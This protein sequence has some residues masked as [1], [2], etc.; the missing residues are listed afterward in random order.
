M[1]VFEPNPAYNDAKAELDLINALLADSDG[2]RREPYLPRNAKEDPADY[3]VRA[4]R[5]TLYNH[6]KRTINTATG[7]VLSKAVS[8]KSGV[9]T[10]ILSWIENFDA[11]GTHLDQFCLPWFSGGVAHGIKFAMAEMPKVAIPENGVRTLKTDR[12]QNIRPYAILIDKEN[13][14][15]W[16]TERVGGV[17]EL[18]E[19]RIRE[20]EWVSDGQGGE[21]LQ[22]RVRVLTQG[23]WK[24]YIKGAAGDELIDSGETGLTFIPIV[25]FYANKTGPFTGSS[26]F[27]NLAELNIRHFQSGSEQANILAVARIPILHIA[28]DKNF[29]EEGKPDTQ[30]V[31]LSGN[32][33]VETSRDDKLNFVEHGGKAMEAGR[34]DLQDLQDLMDAVSYKLAPRDTSGDVT[35]TETN[36]VTAEAHVFLSAMA[37]SFKDALE[38]LLYYMC[39]MAD[40]KDA[41][42]KP[43]SPEVVIN[44]DF[45]TTQTSTDMPLLLDMYREGVLVKEAV[46]DGAIRRGLL[47]EDTLPADVIPEDEPEPVEVAVAV[48]PE[49]VIDPEEA[50][51]E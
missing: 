39:V 11:E 37:N 8:F 42:G 13:M 9:S 26:P 12:S 1:S 14:I 22:V 35:A 48:E 20:Y 25:P 36:V 32:Q 6:F 17:R 24:L 23:A 43:Q 49:P 44:K 18:V 33:A 15:G 21:K 29:D 46:V 5:S 51:T 19:C 47:P 40:L 2:V 38:L 7:K 34:L 27:K 3:L 30:E 4:K 10:E 16:R 50:P 45:G 41:E 28:R 31:V